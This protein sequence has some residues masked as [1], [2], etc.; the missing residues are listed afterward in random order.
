VPL[1][2]GISESERPSIA[3]QR[4]G[5]LV[6]CIIVWVTNAFTRKRIQRQ[7][8][9][10]VTDRTISVSAVTNTSAVVAS[11][12]K[13]LQGSTWCLLH[14][15]ANGYNRPSGQKNQQFRAEKTPDRRGPEQSKVKWYKKTSLWLMCCTFVKWTTVVITVNIQINRDQI[16]SQ[17]LF[18]A[19]ETLTRDNTMQKKI[20]FSAG[21]WR[22]SWGLSG[23]RAPSSSDIK[24]FQCLI[25]FVSFVSAHCA[26][27]PRCEYLHT[28]KMWFSLLAK[29][30]GKSELLENMCK[31]HFFSW[32]NTDCPISG[33]GTYFFLSL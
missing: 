29:C 4:L 15:L 24:I 32:R 7:T 18:N 16:R 8:V 1:K 10:Y 14:F 13:K 2:A 22:I 27:R 3:R 5:N 9:S 21:H 25:W 23:S 19:T 33:G 11:E 30:A 28:R 26:L 31:L 17:Q 6:S 12:T 20:T